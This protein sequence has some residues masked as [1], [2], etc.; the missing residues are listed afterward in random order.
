MD[1]AEVSEGESRTATKRLFNRREAVT[2]E[3]KLDSVKT[4]I[5]LYNPVIPIKWLI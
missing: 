4:F 5:I 3:V 1:W 2:E